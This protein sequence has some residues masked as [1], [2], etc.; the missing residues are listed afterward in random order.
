MRDP[1]QIKCASSSRI[2]MDRG[3]RIAPVPQ[4]RVCVLEPRE[5]G[6]QSKP[7]DKCRR[8]CP[9]K[10]EFERARSV[11]LNLRG[12]YCRYYKTTFARLFSAIAF[13]SEL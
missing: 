3:G 11:L 1:R 12:A 9:P 10:R 4:R 2:R 8:V 6:R 13:V 5:E 7:G